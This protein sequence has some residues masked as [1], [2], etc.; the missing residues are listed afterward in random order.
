MYGLL[1]LHCPITTCDAALLV[2][3]K[4]NPWRHD[5]LFAPYRRPAGARWPA[6]PGASRGTKPTDAGCWLV[7]VDRSSMDGF[8]RAMHG[9]IVTTGNASVGSSLLPIPDMFVG[10]KGAKTRRRRFCCRSLLCFGDVARPSFLGVEV[11]TVTG[12][13]MA[14]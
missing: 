11:T 13:G 2:A 10:R 7:L 4:S 9:S 6:Q 14:H 1:A 12:Y 8:T 5:S 3:D